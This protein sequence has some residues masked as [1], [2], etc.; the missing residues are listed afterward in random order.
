MSKEKT[1]D[2]SMNQAIDMITGKIRSAR[3]VHNHPHLKEP[4]R[5]LCLGCKE[6]PEHLIQAYEKKKE[7][8]ILEHVS[9]D[10]HPYFRR[11]KGQ[12]H[13]ERCRFRSPESKV[14]SLAESNGISI[15]NR[16]KVL[17]IL[18]SA[19][20]VRESGDSPGYSRTAYTKFF[21]H[22]AHQRFYFFLTSLLEEYEVTTFQ[23]RVSA[24][25][26][27]TESG[28]PVKFADIFGL[29]DDI[30]H[31]VEKEGSSCLAVVVGTVRKVIHKGYILIDFTTSRVEKR[32]NSKPFR[33]FVHHEYA[34][35]VGDITLLENQKIACYGFVEKKIWT[36]GAVYQMELYSI[37]HQIYFFDYPTN[38]K[39]IGSIHDPDDSVAYALEECMS[40][41]KRFWGTERLSDQEIINVLTV[42][43]QTMLEQRKVDLA[44]EAGKQNS[45]DAFIV[46]W[47]DLRS[48]VANDKQQLEQL[49]MNLR[50]LISAYEVKAAKFSSKFG[51][52]R[53]TLSTL[54]EQQNQLQ[55]HAQGIQGNLN[56]NERKLYRYHEKKRDWDKWKQSLDKQNQEIEKME[57]WTVLETRLKGILA[58]FDSHLFRIPFGHP[59]W[60]LFLRFQCNAEDE[61]SVVIRA[62]MQLY[63]AYGQAWL[64]ADHSLQ[65]Q[66]MEHRFTV[67]QLN[68]SSREALKG[69][70]SK[71]GRSIFEFLRLMGW[72]ASKSKCPKCDGSMRLQYRN[73]KH[74]LECWDLKCKESLTLN[75][76][77]AAVVLNRRS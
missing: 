8:T 58:S 23:S 62:I 7:P 47:N 53:R 54:E 66:V 17:K 76:E 48:Q 74:I 42:H 32:R 37:E 3:E 41:T 5:Y 15:D 72:P 1:S 68:E 12:Q 44:I 57:R 11:G 20:L 55:Q 24:F 4:N 34:S 35:K 36:H 16:T 51:F 70:Y 56:E 2:L 27:T 9:D 46:S 63:T 21:T 45:Y 13:Y 61:S 26:V 38:R 29:Q 6:T 10:E 30:I 77:T 64:P 71:L 14:I 69:L 49:Q 22:Q 60:E 65:E 59:K 52:N 40:F 25:Y 73:H 39:Q 31:R 28:K 18:T 50:K 67:D 43:G 75:W 33:L 19:K